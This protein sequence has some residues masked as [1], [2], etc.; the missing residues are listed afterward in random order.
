VSSRR[1][2]AT[3]GGLAAIVLWSSSV[4]VSRLAV[5]QLGPMTAGAVIYGL[6]G[7]IGCVWFLHRGE[8][9]ARLRRLSWSYLLGCG[10]LVVLYMVCLYSA[11]GLARGHQQVLEVGLINYLWPALTLILSV[12]LLKERFHPSLALG[13]LLAVAGLVLTTSAAPASGQADA[14]SWSIFAANLRHNAWPYLLALVAAVAWGLYSNL[15]R[16]WAGGEGGWGM[17]LFLLVAGG[18]M[19]F[20]RGGESSHWTPLAV[21]GAVFLAV[22]PG[23][24]G[25][26]LW[27]VAMRRGHLRLVA[28]AA[29]ATPLLSTI[30]SCA[31]LGVLPGFRLW[32]AC[33]LIVAGAVVCGGLRPH[34]KEPAA[35]TR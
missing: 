35:G 12:P 34:T 24:L 27:D 14:L 9:R 33:G 1:T 18:V 15:A 25:Y 26:V 19:A 31:A 8:D 3:I 30:I 21:A 28:S 2:Y 17:P 10:G 22:F 20:L 23:L 13:V 7:M 32:I 16:L 4:G 6:A 29:Y 11:I 5:E